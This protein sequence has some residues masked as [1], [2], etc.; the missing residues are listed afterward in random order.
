MPTSDVRRGRFSKRRV[1]ANHSHTWWH[2]MSPLKYFQFLWP[3]GQISQTQMFPW[4][5]CVGSATDQHLGPGPSGGGAVAVLYHNTVWEDLGNTEVDLS[6]MTTKSPANRHQACGP[7][8][9]NAQPI[10]REVTR[11][12]CRTSSYA[13]IAAWKGQW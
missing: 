5:S 4:A 1:T 13:S 6:T 7:Q 11:R 12:I 2:N 3:N 10:S 9:N 8:H